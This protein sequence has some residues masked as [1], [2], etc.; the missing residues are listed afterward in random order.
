MTAV[1]PSAARQHSRYVIQAEWTSGLRSKLLHRLG[2]PEDARLLE[3]GSG[4]GVITNSISN[5]LPS[6]NIFGVD[7]AH[8]MS[9]FARS[10]NERHHYVT[11]D[12]HGL[13]F[14]TDSFQAAF[15]H[16]LFMWVRDPLSVV[17][18]MKRVTQPGGWV[19]AFAE[20]DYG[21][22]IDHPADLERIGRLQTG[23]L[24]RSGADPELG[25]RL[26]ALFANAGLTSV[27]SGVLGG[28]WHPAL[29]DRHTRSEW[30]TLRSDLRGR[31]SDEE[32]DRLQN[33][34]FAAWQNQERVLFVP[35]FYAYGLVR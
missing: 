1:T 5:Q 12:G 19:I 3:V 28:E 7:L 16:F 31:I 10:H 26:R 9:V 13:P 35:T 34:D 29:D 14:T 2:L 8:Q 33:A 22:R 15:A 30:D 18:E 32:L 20:P 21:G 24:A 17:S 27:V 6:S 23:A 4:T 11:A 25:R